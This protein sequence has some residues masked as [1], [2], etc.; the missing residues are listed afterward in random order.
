MSFDDEAHADEGGA[1]GAAVAEVAHETAADE[2]AAC[3]ASSA[4]EVLDNEAAAVCGS[5]RSSSYP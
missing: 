1:G 3:E 2:A 4:V 5:S